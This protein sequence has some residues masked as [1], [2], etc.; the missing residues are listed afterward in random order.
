MDK[1]K[2]IKLDSDIYLLKQLIVMADDLKS[3]LDKHKETQQTALV[4][5]H[6]SDLASKK[7][8]TIRNGMSDVVSDLEDKNKRE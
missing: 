2:T 8:E 3:K 5:N 4:V 6:L 7:L 1:G